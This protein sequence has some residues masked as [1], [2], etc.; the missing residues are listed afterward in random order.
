MGCRSE[1]VPGF[2]SVGGVAD[3]GELLGDPDRERAGR[4]LQAMLK[5]R[6]LDIGALKRAADG[7]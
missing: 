4:A 5:M 2:Q 6:K 3:L 1:N 7:G